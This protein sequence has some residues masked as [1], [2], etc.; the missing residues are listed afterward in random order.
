MTTRRGFLSILG[1]LPLTAKA[2]ADEITQQGVSAMGTLGQAVGP[3]EADEDPITK[4]ALKFLERK[5]SKWHRRSEP[6]D[7]F[8]SLRIS[9]KK[10]WSPSFKH[11]CHVQDLEASVGIIDP[12]EMSPA[13]IVAEA[14]KRGWTQP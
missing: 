13:E 4:S 7:R 3:W 5:K 8:M 11:H 1:T 6:V 2:A 12:W 10:S 9:T 14:I